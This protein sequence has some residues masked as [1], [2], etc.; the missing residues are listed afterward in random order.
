MKTTVFLLCFVSAFAAVAGDPPT[1]FSSSARTG[2]PITE[3]Q[4]QVEFIFAKRDA[5]VIALGKSD[6]VLSGPLVAGFRKLPPQE[7][8]TR[9]Q[10][11]LRLPLIRLFVPG[12]MERPPGG[13][14]KYFAW[15]NDNCDLPWT[16]AASRPVGA[17]W[18]DWRNAQ[19][20]G[21]LIQL[22]R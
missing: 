15:R 21:M 3:G 16:V 7:N 10:R 4:R 12:P 1:Q 11:F 8:L 2:I 5:P 20:D 6:F 14:G 22:H 13:T 9:T 19:P 18:T 17:R